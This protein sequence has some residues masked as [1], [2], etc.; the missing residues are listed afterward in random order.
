MEIARTKTLNTEKEAYM[1]IHIL[2]WLSSIGTGIS[3]TIGAL[4]GADLIKGMG[5][6]AAEKGA[7]VAS[8]EIRKFLAP[9]NEDIWRALVQS[10]SN[11]I[12]ALLS[13]AARNG[14]VITIADERDY[15]V[16]WIMRMLLKIEEQYRDVTLEYLNGV[17]AESPEEFLAN[18]HLIAQKNRGELTK[19]FAIKI[20]RRWKKI[21][22]SPEKQEAIKKTASEFTDYVRTQGP[23]VVASTVEAVLPAHDKIKA[24]LN[25]KKGV[26]RWLGL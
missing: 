9:D 20:G 5:S 3:H 17:C 7:E 25:Y 23:D 15:T 8:E 19:L 12:L 1:A 22:L 6:K 14:D 11:A 26:R 10:D 2:P 4:L 13:E 24:R 18:L 21:K 16:S